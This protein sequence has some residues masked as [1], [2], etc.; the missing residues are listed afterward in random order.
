MLP[1]AGFGTIT[2]IMPRRRSTLTLCLL[3]FCLLS[4]CAP[5]PA[6][7]TASSTEA[8]PLLS[9]PTPFQP[10][11]DGSSKVLPLANLSPATFTPYPT[12]SS[13][14]G[15]P[16]IP[17]VST[18][19]Q[20]AA[21]SSTVI[22]PLTG[23]TVSD[24]S[25]LN[26]RPLAIKISNYPRLIRPQFG[27]NLADVVYE[28][29]IE[30]LDTRFIA[31]FYSHDATQVGPVRSGRYF[32][33]HI[34]R[35]YHSYYVFNFADPREYSYYLGGDLEKFLVTPGCSTCTCPPFFVDKVSSEISDIRHLETYFNTANFNQCLLRK[36]ADNTPQTLRNGFFSAALSPGGFAVNRIY[37]H[38]SI[39]DYNYWEYNPATGRYVRF[40]E[41][42]PNQKPQHM[43]DCSDKPETYAPLMDAM[44]QKQVATDN[45]VELFVS[46]TFAN[47]NEQQDE[48][49][50]IN[51]IDSGNAFVFRDGLG[52]PARWM[53]TDIDQPLLITTPSG[54]P[55]YFKPGNTFYEVIGDTSTDW[56]D[57]PNWH[58][59][60]HTP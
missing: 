23:L 7:V 41:I 34:T 54:A 19:S 52:Y 58:F 38:Y 24:P 28:Y 3:A 26:R 53:R 17:L 15:L 35:M 16:V 12:V 31:I 60:F 43:D 29:Y 21:F 39:C 4:S 13:R 27:L 49:Y 42:S 57:G 8:L 6:P 30:W 5:I 50:H 25:I 55:I 10:N 59:D 48:I 56:S 47:L 45:V 14:S 11:A 9:T 18:P 40:Q 44:T 2:R 36:G 22:D 46:H 1:G 37:T 20:S 51:L 32:D 33:E